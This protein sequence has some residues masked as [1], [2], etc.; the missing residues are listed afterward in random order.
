MKSLKKLT[1]AHGRKL[2]EGAIPLGL[3]L[4]SLTLPPELE[5]VNANYFKVSG[6][7]EEVDGAYY[8][9]SE[10]NPFYALYKVSETATSVKV[11]DMTE[12]ILS[13][14]FKGSSVTEVKLGKMV[15]I[16]A[17]RAFDEATKIKVVEFAVPLG[18]EYAPI[19]GGKVV[20]LKK[21]LTNAKKSA[22][23]LT[24][25]ACEMHWRKR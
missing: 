19:S 9:G 14:A 15:R 10:D 17:P 5:V 22:K 13:N 21:A 18:W 11:T 12:I 1:I 25:K 23:L 4:E 16:I 3:T 24:N 20:D 2:D 8:I 6:G 7:F